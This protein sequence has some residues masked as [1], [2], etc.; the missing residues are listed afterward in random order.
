MGKPWYKQVWPWVL[1]L[2]PFSVVIAMLITLTVASSYGDNPMVVDDYYKQGRGI[3]TQ[4]EKVQ[5][6]QARSISFVF[7]HDGRNLVL[8]YK[9]GQPNELTALT[10]SFY[11]TTLADKDFTLRL[12]ADADGR[13]RGQL[14]VDVADEP[15]KW[16]LT[17][18]PFDGSWRLSQQIQLPSY[19]ELTLEPL[20]YGV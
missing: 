14:P 1:M 9:T 6:A 12:T 15:G 8:A 4:V 18:T 16:T 2:I 20:T 19:R 5:E 11:H 10:L 7:S 13:F 17:I 3:N